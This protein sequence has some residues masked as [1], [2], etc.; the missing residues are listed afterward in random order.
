MEE[1]NKDS[2]D[3]IQG[4]VHGLSMQR[5]Q[6]SNNRLDSSPTKAFED[7]VKELTVELKNSAEQVRTL[8]SEL[9]RAEMRARRHLALM[10]RDDLQQLLFCTKL[11]LS[12]ALT[13]AE[14]P[15]VPK[16]L[17]KVE[18]LLNQ[19]IDKCQT[20]TAES[21]PPI[22]SYGSLAD[23]L[24]WL[25]RWMNEK[26]GLA[27]DLQIEENIETMQD[28]R[29]LLFLAVRE[30]LFNIVEHADVKQAAI[31]TDRSG[32]DDLSIASL[33]DAIRSCVHP[34]LKMQ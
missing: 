1:D 25:T 28:V 7:Q 4:L 17:K 23:A 3:A 12:A 11:T 5:S 21:S 24:R 18:D 10:L 34:G 22:L 32:S 26:Y 20:L 29:G 8:A 31:C 9:T 6:W 19:S 15:E 2:A 27:G 14:S 30:L 33:M 13:D 16:S